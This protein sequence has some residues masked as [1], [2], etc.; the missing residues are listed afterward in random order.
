MNEI[1]VI[2][3]V[4][5][6]DDTVK[7]YYKDAFGSVIENSKTFK[8]SLK[9][10]VVCPKDV[11]NVVKDY[12][13]EFLNS[14][15]DVSFL[16]NTD[17]T[18]FCSQI[19]TAVSTVNTDY[20]SILEFDDVYSSHWFSMAQEYYYSNED[21][22]V[23]LPINIECDTEMS[24]WQFGNELVWASSFSNNI[25]YIDFDCLQNCSTFNLT[26]GIFN[27][28]DF[29]NV[30]MLKPSIKLTFNYEF[31]LRLTNKGLKAF[32]VPKEGYRHMV[33]REE[34]LTDMYIKTMDDKEIQKWFDLA[35][36]E[37][38]FTE[39]REKGII[40]DSEETLK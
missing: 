2:I 19:N 8:G 10:I 31:L 1:T 15:V 17:N 34:S 7:K 20:F 14:G 23:F 5:Y 35:K 30:G 21:V 33:G 6:A 16:V 11:V 38:T 24:K 26:G 13:S 28:D 40:L 4:H 12:S 18:D 29:I 36:R 22:S 27:T 32:V 25:G 39:D 37:Y 9:V 3:P